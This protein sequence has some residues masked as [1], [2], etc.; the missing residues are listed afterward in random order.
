[1]MGVDSDKSDG[2]VSQGEKINDDE[3]KVY[4]ET[5]R[6][7]SSSSK[8]KKNQGNI[9]S[10]LTGDTRPLPVRTARAEMSKERK[11]QVHKH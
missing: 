6:G 11:K 9:I 10:F 1:M 5:V 3:A 2:N 8:T 7:L 4:I